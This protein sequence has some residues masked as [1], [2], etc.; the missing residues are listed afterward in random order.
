MG[1]TSSG[2]SAASHGPPPLNVVVLT[3]SAEDADRVVA[4]LAGAGYAVQVAGAV[5]PTVDL[6]V[7]DYDAGGPDLLQA[8]DAARALVPAIPFVVVSGPLGAQVDVAVDH[9]KRGVSDWVLKDRLD[10]LPRA[11][12]DAIQQ[13]RVAGD[14]ARAIEALRQNERRLARAQ[15]VAHVGSWEWDALAGT[16]IWSDELYEMYG[17]GPENFSPTYANF[18]ECVV[19]ED[20]RRVERTIESAFRRQGPFELEF[21]INRPDGAVRALACRGGVEFDAGGRMVRMTGTVQ[22][23]SATRA[24]EDALADTLRRLGEARALARIGNW[25][26]DLATK[27][28]EWSDELYELYGV[29]RD[30]QQ[31]LVDQGY[32]VRLYVP[33]GSAWYPYFMRRLAER[34][35]N[36]LFILRNLFRQ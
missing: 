24:R 15:H 28:V 9:V 27:R 8:L 2:G 31:M 1:M 19:D 20:R 5:D 6:V 35:A 29:R 26:V 18:L 36:A 7:A 33:Y 17:R 10:R 12:E 25:E 4:V 3:A 21:R 14:D 22:D 34:P 30:L 32:R 11:V 23:V 13:R 16:V